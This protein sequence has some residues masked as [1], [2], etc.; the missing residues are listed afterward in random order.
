MEKKVIFEN[1]IK[2][3]KDIKRA[4]SKMLP[5]CL[6]SLFLSCF[7]LSIANDMYA[8]VKNDREV[9]M[10]FESPNTIENVSIFLASENIIQNPTIFS[11]YVKSKNK[12]ESVEEFCGEV[13]LNENMSYREILQRIS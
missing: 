5:I 4:L 10:I 12:V 2:I 1:K 13:I 3:H 9:D 7:V 6:F 8:F 11:L